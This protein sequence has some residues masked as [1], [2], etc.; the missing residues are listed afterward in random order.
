MPKSCCERSKL[1]VPNLIE[2]ATK[3]PVS[4]NNTTLSKVNK[5]T[6]LK[7]I[8]QCVPYKKVESKHND[9]PSKTFSKFHKV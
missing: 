6:E 7:E 4:L 1:P 5:R 2:Y 3:I 8:N 9:K